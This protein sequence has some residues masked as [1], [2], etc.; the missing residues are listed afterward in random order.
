MNTHKLP[1]TILPSIRVIGLD[2][3][4]TS[5]GVAIAETSGSLIT[6]RWTNNLRGTPRLRFLRDKLDTLLKGNEGAP[7][8]IVL[9]GYSFASRASHAHSIGEWGGIARLLIHDHGLPFAEVPPTSLKK[10]MTGSGTAKKPEM[11]MRLLKDY[12]L[13]VP[14]ED[15]ADAAALAL[16]GC[17]INSANT[18]QAAPAYKVEALK[19]VELQVP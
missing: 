14:Q 11:V 10:F 6:G 4:L 12:G 1:N 7:C 2:L 9:E 5:T 19:K 3:S 16:V 18:V 17:W 8:V 13:E 15:E